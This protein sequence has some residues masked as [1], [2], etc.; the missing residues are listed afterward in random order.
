MLRHCLTPPP[1]FSFPFFSFSPAFSQRAATVAEFNTHIFVFK[2]ILTLSLCIFFVLQMN[3]LSYNRLL[4]IMQHQTILTFYLILNQIIHSVLL[5]CA[6]R[7]CKAPQS[8]SQVQ[9]LWVLCNS[10][11]FS[12]SRQPPCGIIGF[13]QRMSK[14]YWWCQK[15]KVLLDSN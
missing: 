5:V 6:C 13:L 1:P 7:C 11:P 15:S 4:A 2:I 10:S 12:D 14:L 8:V 9:C 3:K